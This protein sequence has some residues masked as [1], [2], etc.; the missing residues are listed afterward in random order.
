MEKHFI[1]TVFCLMLMVSS[2]L[3]DVQKTQEATTDSVMRRTLVVTSLEGNTIEFVL[4]RGTRIQSLGAF[5]EII[6]DGQAY[7][8][9]SNEVK[10]L[11]YGSRLVPTGLKNAESQADGEL[12]FSLTDKGDLHFTKLKKG[13]TVSVYSLDGQLL[14]NHCA[15]R[16]G[17]CTLPLS[18]LKA[19]V[20]IVKIE[21]MSYKLQR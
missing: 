14:I 6:S 18:G 8:L 16:S 3:A 19:N 10:Q 13:S 1:T 12:P 17:D 20:Y 15:E 9:R 21:N 5:F 7:Y 2:A 11:K 4:D